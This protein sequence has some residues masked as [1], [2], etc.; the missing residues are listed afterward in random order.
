M[1]ALQL[2]LDAVGC[3]IAAGGVRFAQ[4]WFDDAAQAAWRNRWR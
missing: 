1:I 4:V 3:L 2:T